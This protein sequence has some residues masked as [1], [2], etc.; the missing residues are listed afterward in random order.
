MVTRRTRALAAGQATLDALA[1]AAA[2]L[3]AYLVRFEIG[4]HPGPQGAAAARS[5]PGPGA[6]DRVARRLLLPVARRL[7]P[8]AQPVPR[9]RLLHDVRRHAHRNGDRPDGNPLRAGLLRL[10]GSPGRGG[11]RGLTRRL[12]AVPGAQRRPDVR[13]AR[14]GAAPDAAPL[15]GRDRPAPRADRGHR[16]PRLPPRGPLPRARRVRVPGRRLRRRSR[17]RPYRLSGFAAS[18]FARRY[19]GGPPAPSTSTSYTSPSRSRSTSRC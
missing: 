10:S 6:G 14:G 2:F 13:L 3:L 11:I 4:H 9:G 18:R 12:D 8:P 17:R 1:G 16:R 15:P 7:S 19:G 5:V